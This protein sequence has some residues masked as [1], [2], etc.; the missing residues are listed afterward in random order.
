MGSPEAFAKK[1]GMIDEKKNV[2]HRPNVFLLLLLVDLLTGTKVGHHF[3][4]A[5]HAAISYC[6][7]YTKS[8]LRT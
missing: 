6:K 3:F 4:C 2:R 1:P 7:N 5:K 8:M